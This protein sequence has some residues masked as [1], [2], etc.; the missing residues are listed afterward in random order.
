MAKTNLVIVESPA[1]AKTIGKYLGPGY[2]VKASMGH[3]RDLPKSKLGVDVEHGFEPD[4]QPIKGKE[5][6]ISD[7]KKAAKG[8]EK[9]FLAT[10][11][12]REGEAISWHLKEL[13]SIPDD[14]TYRVTFNEITKKVIK[15]S[16][17]QEYWS[18]DADLSRIAPNLGQFKASFYGREKKVE[19]NIEGEGTVGLITYMRTDSLRLSDEATAAA[20]DFILA[21]TARTTTPARPGSTRPNPAPRT[22]TRPS[23]SPATPPCTW[24]GRTRRRR[25]SSPPCPI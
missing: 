19:L 8:S 14:K 16:V 21:T 2:E 24:R 13:L 23:S 12:D 17:P 3:V 6:V 4:Y 10:D 15:A 9:V 7:L 22:P 1:K 5:E 20:K 18:L 11:P 25:R